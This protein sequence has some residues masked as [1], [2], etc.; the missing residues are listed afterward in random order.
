[1]AKYLLSPI[2]Y[3]GSKRRLMDFL[4]THLPDEINTF[5][6]VFGGS[7]TVSLNVDALTI[8]L[9]DFNK[10]LFKLYNYYL[11]NDMFSIQQVHKGILTQYGNGDTLDQDGY[12]R[13]RD[14]YNQDPERPVELL[15][16]L[17]YYAFQSMLRY[18]QSGEFNTSYNNKKG[19]ISR[20]HYKKLYLFKDVLSNKQTTTSNLDFRDI[21][22]GRLKAGDFVYMD[23]PY[24]LTQAVYNRY[25]NEQ[26][27]A[28]LYALLAKLHRRGVHFG[29][30]NVLT[31]K[32]QTNK[33]LQEF[34]SIDGLHTYHTNMVYSSRMDS[35]WQGEVEGSD[36]V[37][38]TN[39]LKGSELS[40]S[41]T[42]RLLFI[43]KPIPTQEDKEVEVEQVGK[44]VINDRHRT[45][46]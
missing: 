3:M 33:Q 46:T 36:E 30:S 32:G 39:Y 40:P 22:Y 19:K 1:M 2:V 20:D 31:H 44:Q 23:P 34:M 15:T 43:D 35:D 24:I 29:I 41:R 17:L 7:G 28:D 26:D 12:T 14:D 27:E 16:V 45:T 37:Y 4:R 13:L 38:I 42:N 10:E 8:Q 5:V 11:T 18:N 21:D 25:W 6:D 9:N